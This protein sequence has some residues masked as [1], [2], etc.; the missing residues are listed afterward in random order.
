MKEVKSLEET[1]HNIGIKM[2]GDNHKSEADVETVP[3][4]MWRVEGVVWD[5]WYSTSD[6][7][8]THKEQFQLATEEYAAL[9]TE[10]DTYRSSVQVLE[11]K[12]DSKNI[13]YTPA[14]AN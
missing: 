6:P 11:A 7:T 12:L 14:R 10:L 3:G 1:S 8:S 5:S 13:P 4:T 2:W 9:R